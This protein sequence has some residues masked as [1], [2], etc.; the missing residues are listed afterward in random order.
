MLRRAIQEEL[1]AADR[2][3][4]HRKRGRARESTG[5]KVRGESTQ[6]NVGALPRLKLPF[7]V[8]EFVS[9]VSWRRLS[10]IGKPTWHNAIT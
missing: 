10:S 7:F 9:K 5:V 1:H 3:A 2:D 4:L 8:R 6:L